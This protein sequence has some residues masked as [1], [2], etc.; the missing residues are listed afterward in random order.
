LGLNE[1][2]GFGWFVLTASLFMG[3]AFLSHRLL[4]LFKNK[5]PDVVRKEIPLAF[6]GVRHPEQ[7]FYFYRRRAAEV[8]KSDDRLL[9]LRRRLI[10]V[11][12]LALAI[13]LPS[14]IVVAMIIRARQ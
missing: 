3:V 1:S 2:L 7:V 8:L 9:R 13:P 5:Y 10:V 11:T 4:Y 6:E 14:L 12:W